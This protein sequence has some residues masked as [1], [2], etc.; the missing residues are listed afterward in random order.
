M[1]EVQLHVIAIG[2]ASKLLHRLLTPAAMCVAA[3]ISPR[4]N[5]IA[6]VYKSMQNVFGV[7]WF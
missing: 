7:S 5:F 6:V 1:F 3:S 4:Q 2:D